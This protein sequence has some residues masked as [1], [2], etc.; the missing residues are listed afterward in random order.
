MGVNGIFVKQFFPKKTVE[1]NMA[2]AVFKSIYGSQLPSQI[3][4]N[5]PIDFE[6]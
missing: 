2:M 5:S 3:R 1:N 4:N 6:K